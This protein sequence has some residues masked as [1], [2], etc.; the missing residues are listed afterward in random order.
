MV[1]ERQTLHS[2]VPQIHPTTLNGFDVPRSGLLDHFRRRINAGNVS[3]RHRPRQQLNAHSGSETDL[4]DAVVR[5]DAEQVDHPSG[6]RLI[7][8]R[9]DD[10]P[11]PARDTL[12]TAEHAHQEAVCNAHR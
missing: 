8:A 2:A 5:L 3:P 10:A 6:T 9:H 12:G 4:Q 7:R 1:F 11:Q